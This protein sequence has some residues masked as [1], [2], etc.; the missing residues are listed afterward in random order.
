MIAKPCKCHRKSIKT[1]M[2]N[3]YADLSSGGGGGEA[4]E[5]HESQLAPNVNDQSILICTTITHICIIDH[6]PTTI[7]P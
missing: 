3:V 2:E 5:P 1:T 7:H 6:A 4:F